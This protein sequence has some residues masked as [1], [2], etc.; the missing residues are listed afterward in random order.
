MISALISA[1]EILQNNGY[2]EFLLNEKTPIFN[3]HPNQ[4]LF[5]LYIKKFLNNLIFFYNKNDFTKLISIKE[6]KIRFFSYN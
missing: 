3:V 2:L 4:S 1:S 6:N 5:K